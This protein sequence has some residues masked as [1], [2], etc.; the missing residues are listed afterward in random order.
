[1]LREDHSSDKHSPK[2]LDVERKMQPAS[3]RI[4]SIGRR[5]DGCSGSGSTQQACRGGYSHAHVERFTADPSPLDHDGS[6]GYGVH[7]ARSDQGLRIEP[8]TRLIDALLSAGVDVPCSCRQGIC[9]SCEIPV[10]E[11]GIDHRDSVL[12][13]AER[14]GNKSMMVC[15]SGCGSGRLVLDC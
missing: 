7:L 15:V 1:M 12:T 6:P 10:L 3:G 2:E 14:A 13:D 11:G 8:G 9:G 4:E 5:R